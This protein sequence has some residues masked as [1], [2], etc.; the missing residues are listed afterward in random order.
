MPRVAYFDCFSGASGDMILGALV[1]AGVE[2]EA[3][4]AEVAKLGLGAEAYELRASKVS[5]AGFAAAGAGPG[6]AF[7][8]SAAGRS[9][10]MAVPWPR[11]LWTSM[12]PLCSPGKISSPTLMR[13]L[14][15]MLA[16]KL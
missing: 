13:P 9:T 7:S 10:V 6:T 8:L 3:L 2:F 4:S 11:T 14:Y 5:R 1:D 12:I 15:I 16:S